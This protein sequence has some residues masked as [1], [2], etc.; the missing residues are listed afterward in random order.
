MKQLHIGLIALFTL[1]LAQGQSRAQ[2]PGTINYQGR[3]VVN[4]NNFSG[5][6]DFKFA[7]VNEAGTTTY[8]SNDGTSAGGAEPVAGVAI[9]VSVG[10][11]AV[12][13]GDTNLAN[14]IAIP[15]SVFQNPDIFLRT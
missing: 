14:M 5:T 10:L 4:G 3:A 15:A 11:F 12:T 2:I 7:L 1:L 13:L 6:S 8:W 9:D